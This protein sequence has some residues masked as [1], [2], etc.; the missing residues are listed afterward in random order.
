MATFAEIFG[1]QG[2]DCNSVDPTDDFLKP[3]DYV[4]QIIESEVKPNKKNNGH[5]LALVLQVMQ[6]CEE[7]GRKLYDYINIQNPNQTAERIAQKTLSAL[8]RSTNIHSIKDPRQLLNQVVIAVVTRN[9]SGNSIRTYKPTT[10]IQSATTIPPAPGVPQTVAP[11][12]SAAPVYA[13]VVPAAPANPTAPPNPA[14]PPDPAVPPARVFVPPAA[15][16][17]V[18]VWQQ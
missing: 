10:Q 1:P 15:V 11:P 16:A 2:F 6:E 9:D 17:G 4:V 14:V 7:K 18:P 5:Y 13:P 3:G 12:A 8:G